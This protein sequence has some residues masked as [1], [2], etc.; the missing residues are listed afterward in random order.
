KEAI[1]YHQARHPE[2]ADRLLSTWLLLLVPLGL[3]GIACAEA[4]LPLLFSAQSSDTLNLARIFVP[5]L[6]LTLFDDLLNQGILLGDHDFGYYNLVQAIQPTLVAVLFVLAWSAGVFSLTIALCSWVLS[7]TLVLAWSFGRVLRRHGIGRP[8]RALARRTF[9]FGFR[10]H[11]TSL[12][13]QLNFGLDLVLLPAFLGARSIGQYSIAANLTAVVVYTAGLIGSFVLPAA[14]RFREHAP[15][16]VVQSLHASLVAGLLLAVPLALA[17]SLAIRLVYGDAFSGSYPL[18]LLLLPGAVLFAA[19]P[20]LIGGINAEN[21]PFTASIPQLAGAALTIPA[22]IVFLPVGGTTAAAI[23]STV[24][25]ALVFALA[26]IIYKRVTGIS[27]STYLP[28]YRGL[29]RRM[30]FDTVVG[31][32]AR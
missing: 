28:R 31:R 22:L 24:V 3:L 9:W 18:L 16:T 21:R 20:T 6:F 15:R 11:G 27:W 13:Q 1:A 7:S 30:V 26:L 5:A 23:V 17:G 2:D 25:Y 14:T 32:R 4:L 12:G 29:S 10:A 19:A 8:S